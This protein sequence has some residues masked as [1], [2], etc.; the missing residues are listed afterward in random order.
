[1]GK[2]QNKELSFHS[3]ERL[4]LVLARKSLA[5]PYMNQQ[6]ELVIEEHTVSTTQGTTLQLKA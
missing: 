6:F 4:A 1:M 2:K 3:T 5:F